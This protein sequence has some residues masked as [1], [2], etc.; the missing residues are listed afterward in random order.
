MTRVAI[1]I[2]V[3]AAVIAVSWAVLFALARTL[4]AGPLRELAAFIPDCTT[5]IRRLRRDPRVPRSARVTVG[6][7]LGYVLLPVDI[8]PDFL[9]VVGALDDVVI[10]ALVLRWAARRVPREAILDAWP[11]D[12]GLLERILGPR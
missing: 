12:P 2:A 10:V 1:A 6:L 8:V 11:G 7:A 5:L 3:G 9:P 4:P